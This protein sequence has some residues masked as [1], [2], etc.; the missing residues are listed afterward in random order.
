MPSAQQVCGNIKIPCQAG[1]IKKVFCRSNIA[2]VVRLLN[3]KLS[4]LTVG[5]VTQKTTM[6]TLNV[7]KT[8]FFQMCSYALVPWC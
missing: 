4:M 7:A 6:F 2:K 8:T 1:T 5:F 3:L